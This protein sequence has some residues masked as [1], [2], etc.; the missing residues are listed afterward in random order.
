MTSMIDSNT[1][2]EEARELDRTD[3]LSE[4]RSQFHIPHVNDVEDCISSEI[5]LASY[6]AGQRTTFR[7]S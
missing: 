3:P 7:R 5:R 4:F 6:L 2:L 1:L